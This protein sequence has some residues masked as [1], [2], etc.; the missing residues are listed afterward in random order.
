MIA[1][2]ASSSAMRASLRESRMVLERLMQVVR[3]DEGLVPSLRD[4]ALYS[5]ALGLGGFP[6]VSAHLELLRGA[7]PERVKLVADSPLTV[8]GG[9]QHAWVVA[10]LVVDLLVAEARTS[11]AGGREMAEA[12]VLNVVEPEEL[13]VAA[14]IARRHGFAVALSREDE[15][16]VRLVL[17]P[18]SADAA[19]PLQRIRLEGLP[20]AQDLW[21][22]LFHRANEAL[23]VDTIQ[24]RRHAGPIRVEEDGRVVGR[25]D[26]DET[27]FSL[28]IG[29]TAAAP[30]PSA[31]GIA[32]Q[33]A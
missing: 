8:D 1:A 27:D 31:N 14:A 15:A 7:A 16:G 11:A 25:Q 30:P 5:A 9:G 22:Q 4:C 28:L 13:G 26:D 3:I 18:A 19:D 32:K 33:G 12:R 17:R 21:W 20:V 2:N 6:A 23:A 24:S 29:Q 10:E